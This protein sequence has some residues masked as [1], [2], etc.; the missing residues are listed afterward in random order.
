MP[1]SQ[2]TD[3]YSSE[4]SDEK[5]IIRS[6]FNIF[7][8]WLVLLTGLSII[9]WVI[10]EVLFRDPEAPF[11]ILVSALGSALIPV[12]IYLAGQTT[13]ITLHHDALLSRRSMTVTRGEIPW[14][15]NRRT[16]RV[17]LQEART[18]R[19]VVSSLDPQFKQVQ[20]ELISGLK[21]IIFQTDDSSKADDMAQRIRKWSGASS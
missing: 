1:L 6:L 10:F 20:V 16:L 7:V 9:G 21:F 3:M 5:I 15:L 4:D 14:F 18:V 2:R 13:R 12:G 8:G 17:S 19:V 11:V